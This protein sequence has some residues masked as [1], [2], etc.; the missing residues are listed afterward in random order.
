[1][2]PTVEIIPAIWSCWLLGASY[3]PVDH[4]Q[5][6]ARL[7][8]LLSAA[9]VSAALTTGDGHPG[10]TEVVTVLIDAPDAAVLPLNN[11][12]EVER[13]D[14]AYVIFTSGSTGEPKGVSITHGNLA[15]SNGARFDWYEEAADRFLMV[16]SVGFD[17]S[18]VGLFWTLTGGGEVVLPTQ[19]QA[20]DVDALLELIERH[21]ITHTLMV[22]TLWGALLQLSLIHI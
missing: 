10:L 3:V 19:A 4:T 14:E 20:H 13:D 6:A 18:I 1:M 5:P 2:A 15:A 17:S 8:A 16:S 11:R 7:T 21:G 9:D 12:V 22:P